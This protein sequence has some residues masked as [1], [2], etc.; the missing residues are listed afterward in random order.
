L[1]AL[2]AAHLHRVFSAVALQALA[3]YASPTPGLPQDTTTLALSGASADDP[4]TPG[5]PRPA[6]G[7]SKDGREDLK[8]GRLSRGVSGDG[9]IPL[10]VGL[11]EGNRSESVATPG[12]LAAWLALGVEGGRGIVAERKA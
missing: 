9:G 11:R 5:A 10:R 7:Q 3:V 8:Q 4:Q 1:D 6:S 12:A 2:C